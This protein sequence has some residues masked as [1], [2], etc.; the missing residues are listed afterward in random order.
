MDLLD[1]SVLDKLVAK[2]RQLLVKPGTKGTSAQ[3]KFQEAQQLHQAAAWLKAQSKWRPGPA[4]TQGCK[5]WHQHPT[6]GL[7]PSLGK[8]SFMTLLQ[9]RSICKAQVPFGQMKLQRHNPGYIYHSVL[10]TSHCS[11]MYTD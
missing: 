10:S 9:C 8:P 1:I 5:Q 6:S 3:P 11:R 2:R 7:G 4:H